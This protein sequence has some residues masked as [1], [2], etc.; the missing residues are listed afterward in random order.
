MR[1]A[2]LLDL[3]IALTITSVFRAAGGQRETFETEGN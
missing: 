1:F 2:R 3:K